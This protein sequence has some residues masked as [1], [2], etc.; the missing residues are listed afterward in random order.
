[1][2]KGARSDFTT[3]AVFPGAICLFPFTYQKWNSSLS[4]QRCAEQIVGP[5]RDSRGAS[6]VPVHI[7]RYSYCSVLD[8]AQLYK[9]LYN[10]AG[11]RLIF[12]HRNAFVQ[13]KIYF[14]PIKMYIV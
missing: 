1:M 11:P 3:A 12:I 2:K 8:C 10:D 5:R 7:D 13:S 9:E 4:A 6:E 14:Y